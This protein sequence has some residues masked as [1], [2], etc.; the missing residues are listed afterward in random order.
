MGYEIV[1]QKDCK[2]R[3]NRPKYPPRPAA[4]PPP[5]WA[6]RDIHAAMKFYQPESWCVNPHFGTN[7][8]K[9]CLLLTSNNFK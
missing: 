6:S 9:D 4:N 2:T 5:A 3:A 8:P 7:I 1:L